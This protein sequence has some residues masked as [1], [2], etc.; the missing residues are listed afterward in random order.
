[1]LDHHYPRFSDV[2]MQRR[3]ERLE[4]L[5]AAEDLDAA[6]V[7]GADR[8]GSAIPWLTGWPV[9]REAALLVHPGERDLL[10]IQF[11]NHVPNARRIAP[12]CD[13]QWGGT[14]TVEAI[15]AAL[16]ARAAKRVGI[17][18]PF[19]Y[20]DHS[21]IQETVQHVVPLDRQYLAIRLVKSPEEVEWLR[22]GAF[23]SDQA[24]EALRVG[25]RPGMNEYE[26]GALAESAY[27]SQGGTTHIHYFGVTSMMNPQS[28]V[29]SQWPSGRVV[30]IGDV[31]TTEISAS[32]WG[33][34][35]QVL[36]TMTV[37]VEP[38]SEYRKLH[39]TAEAT[40]EAILSAVE[41][42]VHVSALV[43]V[44]GIIEDAGFTTC[45]D[46]VHGFG[47]GYLPPVLGSRS[48][49][50][51]PI[52]DMVLEEGMTIVIQPNI[53]SGRSGVQTGGLVYVTSAGAEELQGAPRGLWRV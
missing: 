21:Q 44:S 10:Y 29:P 24:V 25:L 4:A 26:L 33:Y 43:E 19:R 42:G 7:Y 12:R 47:G 40:Y 45:D 50:A 9:T 35:G 41:P 36:R 17:I 18:G 53:I 20:Q 5:L 3:H 14:S 46:L 39:E 31:V 52:P 1:M 32:W 27:V 2:E 16:S 15:C 6:V 49:P 30:D 48:R 28:F 51:G 13:V 11:H 38:T 22:R 8:S 23:L 37:G 34:P